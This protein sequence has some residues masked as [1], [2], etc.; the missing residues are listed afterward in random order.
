MRRRWEPGKCIPPRRRWEPGKCSDLHLP[1]W[2]YLMLS[3]GGHLINPLSSFFFPPRSFRPS[4][5]L[6]LH[7]SPQ[8]SF[9]DAHPTLPENP[10]LPT[11][12]PAC[13]P[14][15]SPLSSAPTLVMILPSFSI[16]PFPPR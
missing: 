2:P 9:S 13:P 6:R 7:I 3:L 5:A 11:A 8:L 10:H 16:S 12:A 1:K 14:A 15:P 4:L